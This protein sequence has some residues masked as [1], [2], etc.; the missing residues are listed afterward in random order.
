MEK[1]R[2]EVELLQREKKTLMGKSAQNSRDAKEAKELAAEVR[3]MTPLT[4]LTGQPR[5]GLLDVSCVGQ[6]TTSRG[7]AP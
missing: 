5:R 4:T 3:E 2:K 1:L 7:T 6:R